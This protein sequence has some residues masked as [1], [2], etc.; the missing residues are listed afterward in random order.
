MK[1]VS[2]ILFLLIMG[3]GS[4]ESGIVGTEVDYSADGVT[5][6]G[7]LAYDKSVTGKRPGV[8]VVHEWWGHNE[9]AR[10]RARMLAELGYTALA[11]DMY[12][13]GKQAA[14]PQDAGKFATEVMQNLEMAQARFEAALAVL[15][16]HESTNKD[17]IAAIGYC[18]GGGVVL[19][20]ARLGL[21][22]DG[23][24]SFHG[25]YATQHPAEPGKVKAAVLVC[26]GADDQFVTAE[27]IQEFQ[28][29]MN[30]AGADF[31]F[32]SYEGAKH[33]Y[34]NPDADSFAEKF[35]LPLAYNRVA[36]E[37]S[38]SDMQEFFNKIFA[39]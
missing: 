13:D 36:D 18:F 35:D 22:L 5:L 7:F 26:H 27:Q 34:T 4:Q 29:E 16:G 2:L 39:E 33:S 31:T 38:W 28:D 24:V 9:Y 25:S 23:V 14:H 3:C 1:R 32:L 11:V 17:K 37:K 10:K 30:N 19:H 21:D 8:I 20:M 12:G 15:Q 6:K